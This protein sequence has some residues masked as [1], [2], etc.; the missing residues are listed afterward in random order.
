MK[1]DTYLD[2]IAA[3][4]LKSPVMFVVAILD[5][6]WLTGCLGETVGQ[7]N[8][9][10]KSLF[11]D[12]PL[13]CFKEKIS[14]TLLSKIFPFYAKKTN[15][16]DA[17]SKISPFYAKKEKI[18]GTLFSKISPFSALKK[19]LGRSFEDFPFLGREKIVIY[20]SFQVNIINIVIV[21]VI[22]IVII[23]SGEM[24]WGGNMWL[25]VHF[26]SFVLSIL[27]LSVTTIHPPPPM[28]FSQTSQCFNVFTFCLPSYRSLAQWA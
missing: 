20:C 23:L 10:R 14:W 3:P 21:I 6:E 2:R 11:K 12:F 22:V 15:I 19:S 27:P 5:P 4:S 17:F 28:F 8:K 26:R 7:S 18:S 16:L 1:Y 9:E 25:I 24:L 13:F